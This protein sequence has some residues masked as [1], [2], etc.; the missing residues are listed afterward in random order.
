MTLNAS[1]TCAKVMEN[2]SP[3]LFD[4]SNWR[5]YVHQLQQL[6]EFYHQNA[7]S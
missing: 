5:Y 6:A 2:Y 4:I 7:E 3:L 1:N